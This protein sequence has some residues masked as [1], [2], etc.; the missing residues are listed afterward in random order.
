MT[1]LAREGKEQGWWQ[2]YDLDTFSTYVGL[3][4]EAVGVRY[5]QS[6]I[7][8]G[9]LQTADYAKAMIQVWMPKYTDERVAERLEVKLKRQRV[10]EHDPPLRVWALLDE[11]VLHRVVGG[12][13][14][15]AEQLDKLTE[16]ST[17]PNIKIQVIAYGAGAH[18]AMGSIF[19]ILDYTGSAPSVVYGEG[20]VGWIYLE[21]QQDID[22]YQNVFQ[23]LLTQALSPQESIELIANI[24]EYYKRLSSS[25]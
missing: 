6:S 17:M 2:S 18:V 7:V 25:R 20:L 5:Y 23:Q 14:V 24:S 9:L 8:P 15:M 4:A 21:R 11:A 12:P 22:R 10:L 16:L 19:N 1:K 13:S 3:E